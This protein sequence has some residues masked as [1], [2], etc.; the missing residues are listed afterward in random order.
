MTDPHFG[1][2]AA[3][4]AFGF[5]IVATMI[6]V[7]LRDYR[8]LKQALSKFPGRGERGGAGHRE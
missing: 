5:L 6:V 3:A 4:Y 7:I 1:F 2:V 8:G